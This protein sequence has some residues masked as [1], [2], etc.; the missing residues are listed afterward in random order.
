MLNKEEVEQ[1][2]V[3]FDVDVEPGAV[4]KS[5]DDRLLLQQIHPEI[6]ENNLKFNEVY[7]FSTFKTLYDNVKLLISK[8]NSRENF[9]N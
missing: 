2:L 5:T 9:L 7:S 3:S 8:D 1:G 6:K 4:N